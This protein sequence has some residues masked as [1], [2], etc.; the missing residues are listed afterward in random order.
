MDCKKYG[1]IYLYGGIYDRYRK[2]WS[3]PIKN[4]KFCDERRFEG[5]CDKRRFEGLCNKRR[6]EGL[7]DKSRFKA[8]NQFGVGRA[9]FNGAETQ[10][11]D[12]F[13]QQRP[14]RVTSICH[15]CAI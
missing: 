13:N 15:S 8:W 3:D 12:W 5:L 1:S 10:P 4:G 2:N 7:C 6:F 9:G 11:K 14:A